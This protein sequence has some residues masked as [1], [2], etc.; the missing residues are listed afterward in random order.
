MPLKRAQA[1]VDVKASDLAGKWDVAQVHQCLANQGI[2]AGRR[3][4]ITCPVVGIISNNN[5]R[6]IVET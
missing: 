5:I 1:I 3:E 4:M 2:L 6:I